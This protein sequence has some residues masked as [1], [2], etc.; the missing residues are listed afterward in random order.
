MRMEIGTK[1]R[2]HSQF[3]PSKNKEINNYYLDNFLY[4]GKI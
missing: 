4:Q 3:V 1:N 2:M